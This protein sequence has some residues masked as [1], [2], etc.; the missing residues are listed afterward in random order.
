MSST[1]EIVSFATFI[2]WASGSVSITHAAGPQGPDSSI[3]NVRECH[4]EDFQE[5]GPTDVD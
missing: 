3:P 4:N 2:G 1:L 5:V